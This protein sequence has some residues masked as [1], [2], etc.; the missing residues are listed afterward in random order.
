MV[1]NFSSIS[2]HPKLCSERSRCTHKE[3]ILELIFKTPIRHDSA[4]FLQWLRPVA[5]CSYCLSSKWLLAL[6]SL[7]PSRKWAWEVPSTSNLTTREILLTLRKGK[8][9]Q[10]SFILN[11]EIMIEQI[12]LEN[13]HKHMKNKKVAKRH[14]QE[15]T[16]FQGLWGNLCL[17]NWN[18]LMDIVYSSP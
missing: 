13:I 18:S 4:S 12:I 15:F 17:I 16:G 7:E 10:A 8:G 1:Q 9:I 14:Q 3:S 11:P 2:W 5:V 6:K